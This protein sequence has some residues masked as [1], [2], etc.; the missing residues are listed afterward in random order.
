MLKR[1]PRQESTPTDVH[2]AEQQGSYSTYKAKRKRRLRR[3]IIATICLV[4]L[5]VPAVLIVKSLHAYSSIM[6]RHTGVA[7]NVLKKPAPQA[8]DAKFEAEGR[9]NILL[10]GVGDADHAGS[11]LS[12]TMIVASV[13]PETKQVAMLSLPRDLYVPIPGYN[14]DKINSA[15]S[16]GEL[17]KAGEGPNL[18]KQ[19]VGNVLD[20]PIHY[21]VR[22]DFTGFRKAI[23]TL[24][25]VSVEVPNALSDSEYP[26]DK[27]QRLACGFSIASG[28]QK[29]N[30][31]IALK[32]ARCRKGNCGNDFG[33]AARQQQI[34]L[35]MR[36]KALTLSTLSDPAKLASLIDTVGA[37]VRT[38][39]APDELT[40]LS[41]ILRD[42][43]ETDVV[44]KVIDSEEQKLVHSANINGASVVVPDIG[45]TNYSS[46]R[47][48]AHT[49][50]Y[51]RHIVSENIP[52]K[53]MNA[54]GKPK[55]GEQ[56]ATL[57]KSYRYNVVSV[58]NVDT[59]AAS[60]LTAVR[61]DV[62][63]FTRRY[64]ENRFRV[65]ASEKQDGDTAELQ[66]VIGTD[67]TGTGR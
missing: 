2:P 1:P 8:P 50:F 22:V 54:S 5:I 38:D 12:D 63:S 30:G 61:T 15:H 6:Q 39:L 57:L 31:A 55:L 9:V 33:R 66:L 27:D 26:C 34:L 64:L 48:F 46:L 52:V 7:T 23:D 59:P 53:I 36:E 24:G 37:H 4:V 67:Y 35:A 65:A 40:R 60:S 25:G 21:Y 19:T 14:Y 28:T 13:D 3:L 10:L 29:M 56:V 62:G 42:V 47:D 16:Y 17:K 11:T 49:L 20:V 58:E 18:A 41:A 51:D 45:N 44:N 43:K 32:Y